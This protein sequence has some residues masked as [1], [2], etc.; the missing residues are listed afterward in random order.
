[1]I[2]AEHWCSLPTAKLLQAGNVLNKISYLN[3]KKFFLKEMENELVVVGRAT[4]EKEG[5]QLSV[6]SHAT[7]E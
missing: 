2:S 5:C 4:S 7:S 3:N 6:V 1:V